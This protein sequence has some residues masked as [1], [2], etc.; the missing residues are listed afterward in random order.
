VIT[1]EF[2]AADLLRCRFAISPVGEV[3]QVAHAC[4][5][6][7]ARVHTAW[8]RDHRSTL[9]QLARDY[10]LRP[11]FA[12]LPER[13]YIP[14]FLTPL[15]MGTLGEI[16]AELA[17]IRTTPVERVRAEIARCLEH[18]K[19]IPNDIA[20]QLNENRAGGRLADLLGVLWDALVAPLW[21]QIR[22]CL[23]HDI[24]HRS[25]ALAGGGLSS[26]FADMSPLI[27]VEGQRLFVDLGTTCTCTQSLEGVGLLL[28]P[29]AFI[30]PRVTAILDTP[31][32]P[33]TLCYPA[34]GAGALWFHSEDDI[35]DALAS[36][37]GRTRA[38]ILQALSEPT[39]T[40]A[41]ALRFGRSAGNISDHLAV[42]R[43]SG[44]VSRA[45]SGRH[46]V[47]ARTGLGETLLTRA[48]GDARPERAL[49]SGSAIG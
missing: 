6:P 45:R 1:L 24:L 12:L 3:F 8:L 27:S 36:L 10:D 2:S 25:R 18:R 9:Q 32:A 20:A 17:Q 15:P 34:R 41:L 14:D 39:H 7:P 38:Q 37:I 16:D 4:A 44:L 46:V 5:N 19:H 35:D 48:A 42:L 33:A 22:D 23:E 13:G 29:S 26:L 11:L 21:P 40:S 31:L 49:T 30:Y 28:I 47:Y 43:S